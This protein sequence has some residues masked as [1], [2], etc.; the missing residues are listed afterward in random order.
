MA[1]GTGVAEELGVDDYVLGELGAEIRRSVGWVIVG[2]FG[3]KIGGHG[4]DCM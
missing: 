3:V 1:D 2:V 4:D